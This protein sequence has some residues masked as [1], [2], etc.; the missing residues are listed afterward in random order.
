MES[1]DAITVLNAF[2]HNDF[3]GYCMGVLLTYREFNDGVIG[4][5]YRGSSHLRGYTG[6]MCTGYSFASQ[7]SLNTLIV[8]TNSYGAPL[9]TIML[10]NNN[11]ES[12]Y[13][14]P[15]IRV[16]KPAQRRVTIVHSIPE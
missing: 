15:C 11:N 12:I 7:M 13:Y 9:S 3:S 5:A 2:A 16:I 4:L 10:N 1:Q 14:A 6:G 8:S